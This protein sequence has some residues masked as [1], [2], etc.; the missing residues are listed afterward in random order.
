MSYRTLEQLE[1]PSLFTTRNLV[2]Y[3]IVHCLTPLLL[4]PYRISVLIWYSSDVKCK[5][6]RPTHH[7]GMTS[8]TIDCLRT[9]PTIPCHHS[10]GPIA[11]CHLPCIQLLLPRH[12]CKTCIPFQLPFSSMGIPLSSLGVA[13]AQSPKSRGVE[14]IV[15]WIE[16]VR[17]IPLLPVPHHPA[18]FREPTSTRLTGSTVKVIGY[19]F[20]Q[21]D[22]SC[23]T[24]NSSW[25]TIT[26]HESR[27]SELYKCKSLSS[28]S[29]IPTFLTATEYSTSASTSK[30]S[31]WYKTDPILSSR[32]Q[33]N[34]S[35]LWATVSRISELSYLP[36]SL[37]TKPSTPQLGPKHLTEEDLHTRT[38]QPSLLFRRKL[39]LATYRLA[40]TLW[41]FSLG[42]NQPD[43]VLDEIEDL[44]LVQF[45]DPHLHFW[46]SDEDRRHDL[47]VTM[48]EGLEATLMHYGH[49]ATAMKMKSYGWSKEN[50]PT[51][52][53]EDGDV[54]MMS[55]L[56]EWFP[57]EYVVMELEGWSDEM[58]LDLPRAGHDLGG[59]WTDACWGRWTSEC[60]DLWLRDD[61]SKKHRVGSDM[62]QTW[63]VCI[64]KCLGRGIATQ[65]RESFHLP[66]RVRRRWFSEFLLLSRGFST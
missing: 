29:T 36:V 11:C 15:Q 35:E 31:T 66:R 14:D 1:N 42:P 13:R 53:I 45:S 32:Q 58:N 44:F 40:C 16:N 30:H 57:W 25:S 65:A 60:N 8:Q 19:S 24:M 20:F 6:S 17:D 21:I 61:T 62:F 50:G 54:P 39:S 63:S 48:E 37:R 3:R 56:P 5:F 64:V 10:I 59:E 33:S 55:E 52:W 51:Y 26:K 18:Y 28:S 7:S 27:S 22:D 2:S 9:I 4:T 12:A 41:A 38:F 23:S 43:C 49:I 46:S 34:T 47:Y